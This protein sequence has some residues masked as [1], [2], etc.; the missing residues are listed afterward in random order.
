MV[1]K[2]ST[3]CLVALALLDCFCEAQYGIQKPSTPQKPSPQY[4]QQEKQ[5][6]GK[7]LDWKY[8]EEVKPAVKPEGPFEQR[9]PVAARTV[10]VDCREQ[11]A[12]VEVQ[13]D[14][15]AIGQFINPADLTIGNCAVTGEDRVAQVLIFEFALQDCGSQLTLTDDSLIY[16][17]TVNYNP[18]ALGTSPVVRTN[19]AAVIVECYYPRRHNVSSLPLE[20]VWVPYSSVKI[21]EEFLYFSLTLLTEDFL[22]ARPSYQ[23][24]LGETINVEASVSQY[25]H[26]P[27]RVFVDQCVATLS[28]DSSSQPSYALITDGCVIDALLTGSRSRFLSRTSDD[29]LQFQLDVFRFEGIDSGTF[30]ITCSLR[31]APVDVGIDASHR[32]CSYSSGWTEANGFNSVCGSCEP[33]GVPLPPANPGPGTGPGT[34]IGTGTGTG[35]G[36]GTVGNTGNTGSTGGSTIWG[37]PSKPSNPGSR[38]IREAAKKEV[39]EWQGEVRLGPFQIGEKAIA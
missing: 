23:Y 26:V 5:N 17:Y 11:S 18:Q 24:F 37:K 34:G 29:K 20:P 27:L 8:P 38:K 35:N 4:P 9:N 6:F 25:F 7:P 15:F 28:P 32:A 12:Y 1:L 30:Y 13:K 14:L 39:F 33:V 10:A 36:T 2:C 3:A 19:P 16:S 21:S 31:A 22:Y